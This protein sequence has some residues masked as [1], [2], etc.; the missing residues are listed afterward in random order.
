VSS[1]QFNRKVIAILFVF[2][3]VT[4]LSPGSEILLTYTGTVDPPRLDRWLAEQLPHVSRSRLQKLI[5]QGQIAINGQSCSEKKY[6][7]TPGDTVQL[8][9]PDPTP[10]SLAAE[11]MPLEVLYEDPELLVINKPKGLVVHPSPG[12]RSGTL[13]NALL[14]HCQDLSGINGEYRPGIVHRL[15]KDTTG[16]LV[17]AKTDRAH[18]HLQ[19]Q[20]KAKTAKRQYLGVVYGKLPQDQGIISAPLGRHPTERQRMAVVATGRSA[21]THW[22][23]LEA[24]GSYTLVQFDLETGRTHQIR[25][26]AAHMNHP[27]LGDPTYTP[28]KKFSFK[29]SGQALHAWKLEFK[30]PLTEESILC[31]APLP[32]EMERLLAYL[33]R[34]R[35]QGISKPSLSV[36]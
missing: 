18:Q 34:L 1:F 23:V 17:V 28:H 11:A 31:T 14:A 36:K 22:R 8:W 7:L 5:E 32:T 25:V 6:R 35:D 3:V 4:S 27:I 29:L 13:V 16:A 15:D 30:H 9:I 19:A 21:V 24:L 2:G 33:R 20:I 12:H 10:I 26:H